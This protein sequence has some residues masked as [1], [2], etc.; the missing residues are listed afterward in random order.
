MADEP[1]VF[2]IQGCTALGVGPE[3]A[4]AY[5]RKISPPAS[6]LVW[7]DVRCPRND[8]AAQ[9]RK[10]DCLRVN[11]PDSPAGFD[12][13]LHGGHRHLGQR[14]M[15]RRG[16]STKRPSKTLW[17]RDISVATC[18]RRPA[19]SRNACGSTPRIILWASATS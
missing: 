1:F 8:G 18:C 7:L 15:F 13:K 5:G 11:A 12:D 6:M 3:D 10:V 9:C 2:R 19:L 16:R 4:A 17:T 14:R